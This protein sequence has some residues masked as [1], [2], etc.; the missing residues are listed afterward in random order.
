VLTDALNSYAE[1]ALVRAVKKE[2]LQAGLLDA[3]CGVA[4]LVDCRSCVPRILN[5]VHRLGAAARTRLEA[6]GIADGDNFARAVAITHFLCGPPKGDVQRLPLRSKGI[7]VDGGDLES[8]AARTARC[9]PITPLAPPGYDVKLLEEAADI[10]GTPELGLGFRGNTVHYEHQC[11]SSLEY[12]L[13]S[14]QGLPITLSIIQMAVAHA[15]GVTIVPVNRPGHFM[16]KAEGNDRV[17][18]DVFNGGSLMDLDGDNA[19][20]SGGHEAQLDDWVTQT[21]STKQVALRILK[22]VENHS[23]DCLVAGAAISAMIAVRRA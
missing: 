22:N 21:P 2:P 13:G 16:T 10:A 18:F 9:D 14:R 17:L 11:N 15:A 8:D 23:P 12:V 7:R 19:I 3:A 1:R 4:L 6:M 5:T 20:V